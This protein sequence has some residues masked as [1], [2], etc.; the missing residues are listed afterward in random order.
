[1]GQGVDQPSGSAESAPYE[2]GTVIRAIDKPGR[3][4]VRGQVPDDCKKVIWTY[5]LNRQALLMTP[6]V[7]QAFRERFATLNPYHPATLNIQR[8]Q[9]APAEE[10]TI[11]SAGRARIPEALRKY[12]GLAES[13]EPGAPKTEAQIVDMGPNGFEIWLA[14]RYTEELLKQADAMLQTHADAAERWSAAQSPAAG[15]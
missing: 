13:K 11:D 14:A 3:I 1:M 2:T 9:I 7:W 6:A 10:C 15:E 12:A 4:L 8:F 5:G